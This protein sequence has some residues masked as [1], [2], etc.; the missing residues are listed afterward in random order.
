MLLIGRDLSPFTRRVAISMS[1]LGFAFERKQLSTATDSAEVRGFN[2]LGRV[3]ALVLDDGEVLIDSA[4]ILDYLDQTVGAERALIPLSGTER[5]H[6]L[7]LTSIAQG[8]MEKAVAAFYERT[9]RPSE[10]Q[11]AP[12]LHLLEGQ[13]RSGLA[14][15][16]SSATGDWLALGRMTQADISTVCAFDF[17]AVTSP[18]L[19]IDPPLP[20]LKALAARLGQLP[21]FLQTQ[22][23]V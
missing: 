21:P 8:V 11:H 12:W 3:P 7:K 5:R 14:A 20:D 23:K 6:V 13:I 17:V 22:P 1:L 9:R 16:E 19:Q 10:T 4:A 18:H 15:L 2:P